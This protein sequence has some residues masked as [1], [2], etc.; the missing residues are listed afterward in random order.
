MSTSRHAIT[1]LGLATPAGC[2]P[3]SFWHSMTQG[4]AL[5]TPARLYG[6]DAPAVTVATV[7]DTHLEHG[8]PKRYVKRVD[9]FAL[10]AAHAARQALND[11]GITITDANRDR[12]GLIIGNNTG[13]WSYVEPQMYPLYRDTSLE[14]INPY[15]AT[16]WF[17]TAPQG[18]I[19]ISLGIE[20]FSKTVAGENLSTGLALQLARY[21]LLDGRLD[22]AVVIGVEAPLTPLVHQ[23][24]ASAGLLSPSSRYQAFTD[25]ADG[26]VLGEGASALVLENA[27]HAAA[28]KAAPF[29]ELLSIGT[30][31]GLHE[32]VPDALNRAAGPLLPVDYVALDARGQQRSD[33]AEYDALAFALK[34]A[35]DVLMSAPATVYGNLLAASM[36]TSIATACLAMRNNM[37]PPTAH[38]TTAPPLG[39]HVTGSPQPAAVERALVN[40]TDDHGQAMALLLGTPHERARS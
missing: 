14:V 11:A 8:F 37:V 24:C 19:S 40:G 5:Y 6:A 3:S 28:R 17:P 33:A 13:G 29:A 34:D 10:L 22:A 21:A 36:A 35:P 20:G 23:A 7:D 38:R 32:A 2:S 15:V 18:E 27:D 9:R 25:G 26:S 1:G 4:R 30:G 31:D 12:I 39:R 16:A